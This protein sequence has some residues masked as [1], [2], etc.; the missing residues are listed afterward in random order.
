VHGPKRFGFSLCECKFIQKA[1][2]QNLERLTHKIEFVCS[3]QNCQFTLLNQDK[4]GS[5]IL[6]KRM[7]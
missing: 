3:K 1:D 5:E 2:V 6:A 4:S 7:I